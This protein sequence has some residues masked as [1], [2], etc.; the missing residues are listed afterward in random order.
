MVVEVFVEVVV[1]LVFMG[2]ISSHLLLDST[3]YKNRRSLLCEVLI[4][5]EI[6]KIIQIYAVIITENRT[7]HL[8][9]LLSGEW[10]ERCLA[11]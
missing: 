10:H 4:Y 8:N 7:Q 1:V 6:I 5:Q 9:A 11:K 3:R 2:R